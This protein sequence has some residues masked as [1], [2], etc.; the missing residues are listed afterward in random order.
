MI[1]LVASTFNTDTGVLTNIGATIIIYI[2]ALNSS[3][4]LSKNSSKIY[5]GTGSLIEVVQNQLGDTATLIFNL[6]VGVQQVV[7]PLVYLIIVVYEVN[8]LI[9]DKPTKHEPINTL[10]SVLA[11]MIPA[12]LLSL[13]SYGRTILAVSMGNIF[14]YLLSVVLACVILVVKFVPSMRSINFSIDKM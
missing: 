3:S 8:Q 4:V 1:V 10:I 5:Y 12:A 2:M 13:F 11:V 14:T 6:C 7:L 9:F